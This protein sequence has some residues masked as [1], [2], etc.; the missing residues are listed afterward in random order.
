[1]DKIRMWY[2]FHELYHAL[3][4]SSVWLSK[5]FQPQRS[6]FSSA[7]FK[8]LS[9]LCSLLCVS[10]A[11]CRTGK[12]RKQQVREKFLPYCSF[13]KT[14]H[15]YF[16]PFLKQCFFFFIKL[17]RHNFHCARFKGFTLCLCE[18]S[19]SN[20]LFSLWVEANRLIWSSI[21]HN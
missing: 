8:L 17:A 20:W 9:T 12:L 10:A 3:D 13:F 19:N 1:M 18:S 21:S 11:V 16:S 6:H 2:T 7:Q 4:T 15:T 14:F 5:N